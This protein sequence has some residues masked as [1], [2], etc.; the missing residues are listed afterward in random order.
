MCRRTRSP[1]CAA[2]IEIN[3][4]FQDL[5]GRAATPAAGRTIGC[6]PANRSVARS[7]SRRR[8]GGRTPDGNRVATA[9]LMT[10][11]LA[12]PARNRGA[13]LVAA[14]KDF[15]GIRGRVVFFDRRTWSR[16]AVRAVPCAPTEIRRIGGRDLS[17]SNA[18]L[19]KLKAPGDETAA[20]AT[21]FAPGE[22]PVSRP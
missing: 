20:S 3:A 16:R 2:T 6:L 10:D 8:T 9:A 15:T 18:A 4:R 11:V 5:F 21:S 7:R 13:A 22:L 12:L 14:L 17:L 1:A 19:T